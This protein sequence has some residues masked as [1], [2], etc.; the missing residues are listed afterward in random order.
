MRKKKIGLVLCIIL[1]IYFVGGIIYN[2]SGTN[3]QIKNNESNVNIGIQIKDY[4]YICLEDEIDIYK[5]EFKIL[6]ENLES[7][8]INYQE[9][10]KSVAKMFI[11]DLYNLKSKKNMYDVG[12][13]EFVY[14]D[15]L[16][17]YK[18]NVENTLYKYME[19]INDGKRKQ[20]LPE[21]SKVEITNFEEVEYTIGEE[22]Y[23]GYKVNVDI[24]YIKDLEYD[25]QA[26]VILV[27]SDKYL[28]VVEK[29]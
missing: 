12:G 24:T 7:D 22:I 1:L 21:V 3:K 26:E 20:E 23:N 6:K 8:N 5:D 25:K 29:N 15:A 4:D 11:I 16:E 17:N 2:L 18:L 27:K 19:D 10:A 28:Y 13:V 9:Y 14:P